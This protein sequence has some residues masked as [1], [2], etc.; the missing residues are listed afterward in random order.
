MIRTAAA[1]VRGVFLQSPLSTAAWSVWL[2]GVTLN[3]TSWVHD[4]P[5]Y[6]G[7]VSCAVLTVAITLL[8][9][10]NKINRELSSTQSSEENR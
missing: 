2:V 8:Y 9:L 6:F 7:L 1:E 10:N 4:G 3:G 5:P